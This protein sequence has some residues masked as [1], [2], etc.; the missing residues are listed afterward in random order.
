MFY[1]PRITVPEQPARQSPEGRPGGVPPIQ[2]GTQPFTP[3]SRPAVVLSPHAALA[4]VMMTIDRVE[5][6]IDQETHELRRQKVADL[7]EFNHRKSQGLLELSRAVRGLGEAARDRRLQGR[8]AQ[9]RLKIEKNLAVLSM[10]L[11]AAQEVS[12]IIARAIQEAE[13]D[14]TYSVTFGVEGPGSC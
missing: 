13:S 9:L 12:A 8:L 4:A 1:E 10:H 5:Q 14:G 2:F 3:G 6:V 11:A 7:R